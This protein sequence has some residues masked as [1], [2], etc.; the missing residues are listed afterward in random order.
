MRAAIRPAPTTTTR[1]PRTSRLTGKPADRG[2]R[3]IGHPARLIRSSRLP[4]ILP[5]PPARPA[6]VGRR[7]GSAARSR[8]RPCGSRRRRARCS[9]AGR[10]VEDRADARRD[11][12]VGDVLGHGRGR[13]DHADRDLALLDD[14]AEVGDRLDRQVAHLLAHEL[15]VGVDERH[16]PEAAGAETTVVG[17][18]AAEVSDADDGDRPVAGEPEL[19]G[20]LVQEVVDV[21]ADAPGAVAS[22]RYE[23][24]L[25]T[26]AA[27]T[28]ASSASR[29]DEIVATV[30]L[31]GLEQRPVVERQAGDGRLGDPASCRA[32]N[33]VLSRELRSRYALASCQPDRAGDRS[34]RRALSQGRRCRVPTL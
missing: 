18:R 30:V 20:D 11:Q 15:L 14:A 24:S 34:S 7:T 5:G 23:R 16:D 13:G 6:A 19:A 31:A 28:P 3:L 12:P 25:R 17:E 10:E 1:R 32:P 21:V 8:G 27:L 26:L 2:D 33:L 4:V 29:S 9:T 22:P